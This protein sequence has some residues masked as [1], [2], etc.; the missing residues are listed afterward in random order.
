MSKITAQ[1]T[2][3]LLCCHKKSVLPHDD[4]FLPIHAGKALSNI[5]LS[6][7]GDNEALGKICDNISKKNKSYCELTALYWAW[8]N[9]ETLYPQLEY[10]GLNHYRRYFDFSN[11]AKKLLEHK[12][13]LHIE[14]YSLAG[15]YNLSLENT[16][17][18]AKKP[19]L[20]L[21]V[22]IDYERNHIKEDYEILKAAVRDN[23]PEYYYSF[24]YIFELHNEYAPYNMFIMPIA[25]FKE[26][27]TWLFAL[28]A[29][30]ERKIDL[31]TRNDY[32]GRV[33]GFM[34]ERLLNVF[35]YK[36]G[37]TIKRCSVLQ[38]MESKEIQ[39]IIPYKIRNTIMF[40]N[41]YMWMTSLRTKISVFLH[42]IGLRKK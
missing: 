39:K 28:L 21:P 15:L 25:L 34:G 20:P 11:K 8:K 32:Q 10:I 42:S 26:Y 2:K 37:V 18:T 30:V 27:C 14:D 29:I 7:Q 17:I 1:N 41:Y 40:M 9:I 33:F 35:L 13:V 23:F 19:T 24:C 38:Y 22:F 12:D 31:S 5:D 16:V 6:I 4:I 3:I 36:K